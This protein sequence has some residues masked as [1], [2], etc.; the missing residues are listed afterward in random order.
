MK[1]V[2]PV[3][4]LLV[5]SSAVLADDKPKVQG[6][7]A[8]EAMEGWVAA[9]LAGK[10]GEADALVVPSEKD[11]I[12]E[13]NVKAFK[14]L[15]GVTSLKVTMVCVSDKDGRAVGV[16]EVV[17]FTKR[18]PGADGKNPDVLFFKFVRMKDKWLLRKIEFYPE[19]GAKKHV[20][21]F[22]TDYPDAQELPP[23]SKR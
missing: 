8:R 7:N 5:V 6:G 19:A 23:K 13:K 1:R 3:L 15:L 17:K 16:S 18:P 10:V 21:R 22:R 20:E 14:E 2:C 11:F 12:G 4:V 9:V